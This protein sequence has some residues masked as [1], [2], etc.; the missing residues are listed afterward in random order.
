MEEYIIVSAKTWKEID[1]LAVI[2]LNNQLQEENI[3]N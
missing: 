2:N 1:R 3:D